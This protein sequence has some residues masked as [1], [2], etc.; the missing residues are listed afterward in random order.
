M[1]AKTRGIVFR[2]T[3]FGETSLVVSIFTEKY[4]LRSYLVNGVRSTSSRSKAALFQPLT[5]LDL[6]VYH[7]EHAEILRLK[8]VRVLYAYRHLSVD[9]RK[10]ALALFISEVLNRCVKEQSHAD[11]LCDFL[12]KALQLLDETGHPEDFHLT[13]MLHLSRHLGFQPQAAGDLAGAAY[14]DSTLLEAL[15]RLLAAP[16]GAPLAL[17]YSQRWTLL[18]LLL[19]FFRD[20]LEGLGSFKSPRV[21]KEVLS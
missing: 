8:E 6:V 20:H 14:L 7:K 15:H 9:M 5:Q 11:D 3:R 4:G 10:A 19:A 13:F 21:L 2:Q 1:L 16:L 17:T 18:D 12:V